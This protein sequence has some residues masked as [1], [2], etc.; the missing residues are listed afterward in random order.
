MLERSF[1]HPWLSTHCTW[2]YFQGK[3]HHLTHTPSPLATRTA[4]A[5]G[6]RPS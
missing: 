6:T 1:G 4:T 3:Y 5:S 2:S